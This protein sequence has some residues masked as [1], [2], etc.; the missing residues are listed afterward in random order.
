MTDAISVKNLQKQQD[1][2][3]KAFTDSKVVFYKAQES[4]NSSKEKLGVFNDKYGR[5]LEMMKED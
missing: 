3:K 2:L 1:A 4:L 5:V